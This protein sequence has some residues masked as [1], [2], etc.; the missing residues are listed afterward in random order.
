MNMQEIRKI[1]KDYQIK[2]AKLAKVDLIKQI[3]KAEG[4]FDCFATPIMGECDQME[5]LWRSDCLP[6]PKKK[7][8]AH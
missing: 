6:T 7:A 3:Q 4:H 2:T 5:C 8:A 1:A